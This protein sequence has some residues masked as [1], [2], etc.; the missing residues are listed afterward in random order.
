M[1]QAVK[2][3]LLLGRQIRDHPM[4]EQCSLIQQSLRRLHTLDDN[5]ASQRM[6]TGILFRRKL[7]A[8]EYNHRQI[9]Q[10]RNVTEAFQHVEA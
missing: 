4:Q 8:G 10:G 2:Q 5:A 9:A 3:S 7:L 6:Q 1:V